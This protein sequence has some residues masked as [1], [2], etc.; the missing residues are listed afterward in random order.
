MDDRVVG[1]LILIGSILGIVAYFWLVFISPWFFLTMQLTA[2]VAVAA[3]LF[4]LAWIGYTLVTTPPPEP[5]EGFFEEDIE[6]AEVS[7]N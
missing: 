4:I 6:E 1:V 7:E 2:F 3:V 5:I